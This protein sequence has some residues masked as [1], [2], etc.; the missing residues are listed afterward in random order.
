MECSKT[1]KLDFKHLFLSPISDHLNWIKRCEESFFLQVPE[2]TSSC[3]RVGFPFH[4][5]TLLLF[6]G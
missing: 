6:S 1:F 4:H 2:S 5:M 3:L